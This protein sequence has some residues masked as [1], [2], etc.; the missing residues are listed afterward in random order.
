MRIAD[1]AIPSSDATSPAARG[2]ERFGLA[3]GSLAGF[4]VTAFLVLG[5]AET[6]V[7]APHPLHPI[8]EGRAAEIMDRAFRSRDI[9][10][11]RN[12]MVHLA[13]DTQIRLETAAIDRKFG[14]AYLTEADEEALGKS[15]PERQTG[16]D[17]LLVVRGEQGAHIL[18]LFDS[19][20]VE[21]DRAGESHT[22][23]TIAAERKL[24]RDVRDFL[25]KATEEGWP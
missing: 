25:H 23:T 11:E 21:D 10:V 12:R 15:I 24:A 13:R 14:V 9:G 17:A 4:A 8:S 5:C 19:D 16:S 1:L 20:Y 2:H 7:R 3:S 22:S 6:P 18:V